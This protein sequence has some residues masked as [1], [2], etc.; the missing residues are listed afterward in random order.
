ME[1]DQYEVEIK[2][3]V[4]PSKLIHLKKK[5]CEAFK[6]HNHWYELNFAHVRTI[7]CEPKEDVRHLEEI[8]S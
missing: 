8:N 7:T 2:F 1:L 6:G 3:F 5:L 4:E